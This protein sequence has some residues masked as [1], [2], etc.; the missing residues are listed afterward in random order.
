MTD[1][2]VC[3]A[4]PQFTTDFMIELWGQTPDTLSDQFL[5]RRYQTMC[6]LRRDG[7]PAAA[8]RFGWRSLAALWL[9]FSI[10]E[11]LNVSTDP[12]LDWDS[13]AL[14]PP[15]RLA[16]AS[17]PVTIPGTPL[18]AVDAVDRTGAWMCALAAATSTSAVVDV[19]GT[20][21]T[22]G[23]VASAFQKVLS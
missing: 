1:A 12:N 14:A 19:E 3:P 16:S 21:V 6:D 23:I 5:Q 11:A 8:E 17:N 7:D 10:T 15:E 2:T 18:T 4:A 22:A 13:V 20:A 9:G